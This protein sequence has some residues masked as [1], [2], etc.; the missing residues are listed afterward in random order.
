[1]FFGVVFILYYLHLSA[2]IP[3]FLRS[4]FQFSVC[5]RRAMVLVLEFTLVS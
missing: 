5:I 1:M 3:L 4:Y 2:G